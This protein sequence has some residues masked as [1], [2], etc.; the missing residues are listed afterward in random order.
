MA[1]WDDVKNGWI[2]IAG[3]FLFMVASL[4]LALLEVKMSIVVIPLVV[5]SVLVVAATLHLRIWVLRV[6]IGS[7]E[8]KGV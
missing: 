2:V 6:L 4:I 3:G 8:G 5:G 1:D 7:R